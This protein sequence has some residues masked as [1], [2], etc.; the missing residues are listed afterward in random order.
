V[1]FLGSDAAAYITG[2]SLGVDGGWQAQ[3]VVHPLE[4]DLASRYGIDAA[5]GLRDKS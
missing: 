3:A 1:A 4:P 2:Q 5:T